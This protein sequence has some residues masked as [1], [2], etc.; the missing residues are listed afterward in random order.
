MKQMNVIDDF[1]APP[2]CVEDSPPH[3]VLIEKYPARLIGKGRIGRACIRRP[4]EYGIFVD[5]NHLF[6]GNEFRGFAPAVLQIDADCR[7]V[8]LRKAKYEVCELSQ[9]VFYI[10]YTNGPVQQLG[11]PDEIE[12]PAC[13]VRLGIV[14]VLYIHRTLLT[15]PEESGEEN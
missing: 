11:K 10:S 6:P 12:I 4:D 5:G 3:K 1:Y 9:A 14:S 15:L 2:V 7:R 13:A 8:W